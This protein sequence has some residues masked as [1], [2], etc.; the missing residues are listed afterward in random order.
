MIVKVA[1]V[2]LVAVICRIVACRSSIAF[3]SYGVVDGISSTSNWKEFLFC[4]VNGLPFGEAHVEPFPW[5]ARFS[6]ICGREGSSILL[7]HGHQLFL[8]ADA[9]LATIFA[10]NTNGP[11]MWIHVFCPFAI[12]CCALESAI[13]IQHLLLVV[14]V[15][16]NGFLR[17]IPLPIRVALSLVITFLVELEFL[18]VPLTLIFNVEHPSRR[19]AV[20]STIMMIVTGALIAI[21][22]T[23]HVPAVPTRLQNLSPDVGPAWYLWQLLPPVFDRPYTTIMRWMPLFMTA[24]LLL[25]SSTTNAKKAQ[26]REN[27]VLCWSIACAVVCKRT[28]SISDVLLV[29][30]LWIVFTPSV[31]QKMQNLFFPVVGT[32]ICIPLQRAFFREWVTTRVANANWLFFACVF[33]MT[34]FIMFQVSYVSAYIR[35]LDV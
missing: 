15:S 2:F 35:Q 23:I 31:T 28:C 22:S 4:H 10:S 20:I 12:L 26:E 21:L 5:L 1:G 19:Q 34:A 29:A 33:Q 7:A 30:K 18:V 32:C 13:P 9:I 17:S 25:R 3:N 6:S 16:G 27:S 14:L 11:K 8:F 24:P